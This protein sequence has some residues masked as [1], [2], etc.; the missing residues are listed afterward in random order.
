MQNP[1]LGQN[2]PYLQEVINS[3]SRDLVDNYNLSTQPAFNA[4]QVRSGSFGNDGVNQMNSAA[5]SNLQRNL[6]DLT[7]KLR[8]N[9]Y[10][11]QQG[12]Y[13]W[14]QDFNRALF[15]DAYTQ[16]MGNLQTGIGL[17]GTL[18]GYNQG[19]LNLATAMRDSPLNYLTQFTN[20][21]STVGRGGQTTTT[22]QN[23]GG[24]NL[25]TAALGGAQLGNAAMNWWNNRNYG[26][27][28]NYNNSS[29]GNDLANLGSS[30]N[31]WGTGG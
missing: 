21:A 20:L 16:N 26:S 31:W 23:G 24:A 11:Q 28:S 3:A 13:Q 1:F 15:N 4:A 2:N 7:S 6:G 5:Q 25:G 29:G 22:T 10:T 12:M 19:D 8:F 18:A 30:N 14:D 27:G 17:L 9:D